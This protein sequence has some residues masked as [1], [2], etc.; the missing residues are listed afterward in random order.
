MTS[1]EMY[2]HAEGGV[3]AFNQGGDVAPKVTAFDTGGAANNPYSTGQIGNFFYSP[4]SYVDTARSWANNF[5]NKGE[6]TYNMASDAYTG[7][8]HLADLISS[9]A[10]G[11]ANLFDDAAAQGVSRYEQQYGP[12]MKQFLETAKN[13]ASPS[14]LARMRGQAVAGVGQAFDAQADS[15]ARSLKGYGLDPQTVASRLDATVRT[16][17]AA[18]QAAAGTQSDI[19]NELIGQQMLGQAVGQGQADAGV[20]Q[21]FAGVGTAKGNQAIN[22]QLATEASRQ[23]GMGSPQ[24]W[25]QL[26]STEMAQWPKAYLD[27]MN[28]QNQQGALWNDINRTNIARDQQAYNQG[29]GFGAIAGGL[30]GAASNMVSFSPIKFSEG[31]V[32]PGYA[33]GGST[34]RRFMQGDYYGT[35]EDLELPRSSF[36]KG[37]QATRGRSSNKPFKIDL[38]GGSDSVSPTGPQGSG[39]G[40]SYTPA[41]FASPTG[42]VGSG[43]GGEYLPGDLDAFSTGFAHGGVGGT[44]GSI[45]GSIGGSVVGGP[46]GGYIGGRLGRAVGGTAEDAIS[47]HPENI[48]DEWEAAIPGGDMI[49]GG[50]GGGGGG[51]REPSGGIEEDWGYARGGP[52]QAIKTGAVVPQ[53]AAVPGIKGPDRVPAMVQP[54]EGILPLRVMQHIGQKGL[55]A[56]IDK[57]DKDTGR[58]PQPAAKGVSK[59]M[60]RQAMQTGPTFMSPGAMQ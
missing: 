60:P 12:A 53:S 20:T 52:A 4:E 48:D 9:G 14:N 57:V 56:I 13:W 21:G 5:L 24:G 54:G 36:E 8:K 38:S 7:N 26:G 23:S 51:G 1:P 10:M 29:S 31:G 45:V 2:Y 46:I 32:V 27:A 18:A 28:T 6:Q 58:G 35:P 30:L 39:P 16:Q 15:A 59:P 47:G 22:T 33:G 42:P 19:N 25:G 44:I 43:A 41:D 17:R 55:Q 34:Y 50:G 11:N 3:V 49:F 40:G 37:F